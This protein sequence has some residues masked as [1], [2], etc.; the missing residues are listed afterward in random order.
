MEMNRIWIR[1]DSLNE[2]DTQFN[3]KPD[4]ELDKFN[5]TLD[6]LADDLKS[7]GPDLNSDA[8]QCYANLRIESNELKA[9]LKKWLDKTGDNLDELGKDIKSNFKDFRESLK[10]NDN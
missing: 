7:A 4:K 5:H 10:G 6:S 2:N 3:Q 8:N 1:L 9:K